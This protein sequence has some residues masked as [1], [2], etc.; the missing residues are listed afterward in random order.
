MCYEVPAGLQQTPFYSPR[1]PTPYD[2]GPTGYIPGL[3]Y[4]G[5]GPGP[6][7]NTYSYER[8]ERPEHGPSMYGRGPYEYGYGG[9]GGDGGGR[10]WAGVDAYGGG[11]GNDGS[12]GGSN[13][14]GWPG[15]GQGHHYMQPGCHG[16]GQHLHQVPMAHVMPPAHMQPAHMPPAHMPP[17]HMPPAH[18]PPHMS[19]PYH[20]SRMAEHAA[21]LA[22]RH[23]A[24][25][26][27]PRPSAGYEYPAVAVEGPFD[28]SFGSVHS[29]GGGGGAPGGDAPAGHCPV[30]MYP[31]NTSPGVAVAGPSGG[32]DRGD[33]DGGRGEGGG[34]GGGLSSGQ[35][36]DGDAARDSEAA[37][38][39]P[40]YAHSVGHFPRA[41]ALPMPE[42]T[43]AASDDQPPSQAVERHEREGHEA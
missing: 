17:A 11:G 14:G 39:T 34:G 28:P 20:P 15:G 42:R 32:G 10:G 9:G 1:R 30:G 22:G 5:V 26:P 2:E 7:Y 38:S 36:G 43:P 37:P 19:D 16:V 33:A 27:P 12:Y 31:L 8:E 29:R 25:A 4:G 23:A 21:A 35:G 3:G 40:Y 24:L 18:M 13:G 6:G 41:S